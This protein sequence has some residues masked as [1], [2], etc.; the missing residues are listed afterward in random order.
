MTRTGNAI[1]RRRE[2]LGI[3]SSELA[4]AV[5]VT[6]SSVCNVESGRN[7]ILLQNI[8]AYAKA[9]NM[10][11]SVIWKKVLKDRGILDT[12]ANNNGNGHSDTLVADTTQEAVETNR[13]QLDGDPVER[14]DSE[15]LAIIID[16]INA[17][18]K[19][20]DVLKSLLDL[21]DEERE[22]VEQLVLRLSRKDS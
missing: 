14:R 16:V 9:L 8:P 15:T 21:E 5:G 1:R 3:S 11:A 20:H 6:Q 22:L 2:Q 10:Q 18:G 12:K 17:Q 4:K 13:I 7:L 19:K